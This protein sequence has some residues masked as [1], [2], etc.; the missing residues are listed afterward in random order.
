[1]SSESSSESS[2]EKRLSDGK[3]SDKTKDKKSTSANDRGQYGSY[4]E[5]LL[6]AVG[7]C[8]GFGNIW[9][10]PYRTFAN[11]GGA[12]LIPYAVIML[13]M[14][15]PYYLMEEALA[16]YSSRG[17]K[18]FILTLI[19]QSTCVSKLREGFTEKV[20]PL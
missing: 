19:Y 7:Y 14:G 3:T 13:T 16:Q 12:F 18:S 15:I 4:V 1:M 20:G 8:I 9:R 10:F 2:H 17:K 6:S 11:G 5:F